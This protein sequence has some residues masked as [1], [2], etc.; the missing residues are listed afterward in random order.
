MM[1]AVIHTAQTYH[2]VIEGQPMSVISRYH[3]GKALQ[4]LQL[5]LHDST[6]AEANI[7][8]AAVM[9]LATA[10]AVMGDITSLV[11]H[12]DGLYRMVTLRGG[13]ESLGPGSMI[14]HKA[15]RYLQQKMPPGEITNTKGVQT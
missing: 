2:D 3:L 15:Q 8:M 10:A 6:A 12:M 9:S 5:E 7:T 4:H 11:M 1:H 14:Q 13:L